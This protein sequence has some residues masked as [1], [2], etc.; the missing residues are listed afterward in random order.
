MN[1]NEYKSIWEFTNPEQ[2]RILKEICNK[3]FICRNVT[4]DSFQL[5]EQ[6]QEIDRLFKD[7]E[8]YN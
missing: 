2:L 4:N 7:T 6:L 8:N 1:E 5:I 3:I